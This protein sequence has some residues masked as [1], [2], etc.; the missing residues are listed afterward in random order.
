LFLEK[1]GVAEKK[2]L[3]DVSLAQLFRVKEKEREKKERKGGGEGEKK[4]QKTGRGKRDQ[5]RCS[6]T[7]TGRKRLKRTYRRI[8]KVKGKGMGGEKNEKKNVRSKT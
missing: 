6:A 8:S 2:E 1:G 7:H 4:S 5:P 3:R